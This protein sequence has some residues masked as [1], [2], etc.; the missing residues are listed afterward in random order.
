MENASVMYK[1]VW[2][3]ESFNF[4]DVIWISSMNDSFAWSKGKMGLLKKKITFIYAG[5]VF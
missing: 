4:L 5:H 1:L 3:I 2:K